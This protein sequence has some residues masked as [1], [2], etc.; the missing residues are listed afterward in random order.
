MAQ[1]RKTRRKPTPRKT[2]RPIPGWVWMLIGLGLGLGI[3][4]ILYL[5]GADRSPDLG[6]L[7]GDPDGTPAAMPPVPATVE[8]DTVPSDE[9]PRFRYYE[10]LPEDEIRVPE[11]ERDTAAPALPPAE[12]PSEG[13]PVV[14]QTGSFRRFEQA[15]EMKAR[16]TLIGLDPQVH[17]VEIQ[18]ETWYR[19]YLGPFSDEERVRQALERLRTENIEALRLR[20]QG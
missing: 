3:A 16:L 12:S 1:A 20:Y 6:A 4:A 18:G 14:L 13:D 8:R 7:F 11:S 5:Q 10:L 9:E 15:D 2:S 19:V 17:E